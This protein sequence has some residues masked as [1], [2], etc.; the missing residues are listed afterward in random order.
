MINKLN[1]L[2]KFIMS[3]YDILHYHIRRYFFIKTLPCLNINEKKIVSELNKKGGYITTLDKI[4][5]QENMSDF[6]KHAGKLKELL[7]SNIK[8][9]KIKNYVHHLTNDQFNKN[10]EIIK[11]GLC[12]SFLN[13]AEAYIGQPLAYRGVTVRGDLANDEVVETRLWHVDGEDRK[14]VKIIL[15]LD[16]VDDKTGPFQFISKQNLPRNKKFPKHLNACLPGRTSEEDM[17]KKID[18]KLWI[19]CTGKKDTLVVVD[20]CSVYHRGKLPV[21]RNRYT[22]FYC[23][24]SKNPTYPEGCTELF[25]R[26]YFKKHISLNERQINALEY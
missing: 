17:L 4:L 10:P 25:D 5:S 16:D 15:Y 26:E 21:D 18:D 3:S 20:T 14:I 24:N 6:Q 19:T 2:A 11:L 13:I 7:Q 23:Y 8:Q 1:R 22:A 9:S 12:D